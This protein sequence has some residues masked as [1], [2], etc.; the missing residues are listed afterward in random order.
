MEDV[1]D[2]LKAIMPTLKTVIYRQHNAGCYR[3]GSTIIGASKASQF[4]GVTLKRL[5]F[6]D[7]QAGKGACDRKA[8]TIK[9][10]MRIYLNEG[11][12]IENASQMVDA[13]R[14]SGGVSGLHVTLCEMA[15]PTTSTNVKFDSVSGVSSVE[16]GKDC[17]TTLKAYGIGPGKTVKKSTF[18][19]SNN[20]TPILRLSR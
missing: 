14:S 20:E 3:S 13:M 15:N 9:A 2:K 7:P 6:S 19:R 8:A 16:Y 1:I 4:H 10:H 12:D 18:I 11:N 17:I 5:D